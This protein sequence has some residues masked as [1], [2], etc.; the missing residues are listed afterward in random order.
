MLPGDFLAPITFRA[1]L[2]YIRDSSWRFTV[3]ES[4]T[5][6]SAHPNK[7]LTVSNILYP[8]CDLSKS[9]Y[10]CVNSI[11]ECPE[12]GVFYLFTAFDML[13]CKMLPS[14]VCADAVSTSRV[15]EIK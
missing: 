13:L 5:K 15:W 7:F 2:R 10:P 8:L 3:L 12:G 6:L 4:M 1:A 14:K 11:Q 9:K